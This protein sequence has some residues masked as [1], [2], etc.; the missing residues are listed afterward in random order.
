V[1][2]TRGRAKVTKITN[3]IR[4]ENLSEKGIVF[5]LQSAVSHLQGPFS[6]HLNPKKDSDLINI[7]DEMIG[8]LHKVQYLFTLH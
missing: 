1:D 8:L 3:T 5:F 4:I 7:R 2:G 6:K